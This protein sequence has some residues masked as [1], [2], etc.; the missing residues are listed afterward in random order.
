MG[1]RVSSP[2][3]KTL[4]RE[5]GEQVLVEDG[6]AVVDEGERFC[7]LEP[8]RGVTLRAAARRVQPGCPES[9][10]GAD[11]GSDDVGQHG[12]GAGG[13]DAFLEPAGFVVGQLQS[14]VLGLRE[15][16]RRLGEGLVPDRVAVF[17]VFGRGGVCAHELGD[18]GA[19]GV[20]ADDAVGAQRGPV[21]GGGKLLDVPAGVAAD[22][23][24]LAD[25][26]EPADQLPLGFLGPLPQV[27]RVSSAAVGGLVGPRDEEHVARA[28]V[29]H[30]SAGEQAVADRVAQLAHAEVIGGFRRAEELH[31]L[32]HLRVFL[33]GR[34]EPGDEGGHVGVDSLLLAGM[35]SS[36]RC[37]RGHEFPPLC[38]I[39]HEEDLAEDQ[40]HYEKSRS[41]HMT[42]DS[43]L[44]MDLKLNE[45]S[46]RTCLGQR[47]S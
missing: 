42:T 43:P 5:L 14:A 7:V 12:A 22:V 26:L 44:S 45:Q 10:G 8:L 11:L 2:A 37:F 24:F 3:E 16:G 6:G 27:I 28:Q 46:A 34:V 30:G 23:A 4:R 1:S 38:T 15:A 13:Q 41:E 32:A 47:V 25:L 19:V 31:E 9:R 21:R 18:G 33:G 17:A 40:R 36:L 35:I 20:R 29:Q 39:G